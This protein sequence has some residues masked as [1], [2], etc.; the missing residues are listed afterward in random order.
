MDNSQI[1]EQSWDFPQDVTLQKISLL[2]LCVKSARSYYPDFSMTKN[3]QIDSFSK[4]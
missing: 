1:L 4:S 3:K 2:L